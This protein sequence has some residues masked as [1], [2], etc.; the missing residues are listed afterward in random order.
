MIACWIYKRAIAESLD[1]NQP[2]PERAQS[3]LASCLGCRQ[4][5]ELEHELTRQ[6]IAGANLHL[7]SPSPFLRAKIMA[8]LD[9]PDIAQSARRVIHPLWATALLI[10]SLG[11]FSILFIRDSQ[12]ATHLSVPHPIARVTAPG[13]DPDV[14][15][16]IG[17]KVLAW[18]QALDQPLETEMKSVVNDAQTA[19]QLLAQNFL[20]EQ[21]LGSSPP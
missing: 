14:P 16:L 21:A 19:I 4:L 3:H 15:A 13:S 11:V 12:H 2:L 1:A 17:G 18:T 7:Q 8:S 10:A 5:Y 6:L 9:R 20:P